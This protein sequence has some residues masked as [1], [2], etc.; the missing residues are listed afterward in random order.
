MNEYGLDYSGITKTIDKNIFSAGIH[1]LGVA[2]SFIKFPS[3]VQTY[4]FSNSYEADGPAIRSRTQDGLEVELEVSFQYLYKPE[5]LYQLYMTYGTE[6]RTP[7][8]KIAIDILTDTTTKYSATRFFF[9]KEEISGDMH[10]ILNNS[11]FSAFC[12]ST[13][14]YFQLKNIDLPDEY[15]K[16]I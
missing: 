15:E 16:A 11:T 10:R 4:E 6:F 9:D 12:F 8:Q 14:E 1:F 7:C 3:T 2:H 5:S 13:V